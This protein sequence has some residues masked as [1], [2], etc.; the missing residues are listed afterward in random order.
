VHIPTNIAAGF[1]VL[2]IYTTN[3]AGE[4]VDIQKTVYVAASSND[5]DGDGVLNVASPCLVVAPT[6]VDSDGDGIDDGCDADVVATSS[7]VNISGMVE[8][9]TL[10]E[11]N[12]LTS[13]V[14]ASVS[15][16]NDMSRVRQPESVLGDSTR[17]S[18]AVR[19]PAQK[20][21]A[22]VRWI[23]PYRLDW[24]LVSALGL[25]ITVIATCVIHA[26]TQRRG[27]LKRG[28]LKL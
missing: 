22:T 16:N 12:T 27:K 24:K 21:D 1:H 14:T 6:G 3:M 5:Y 2:H 13:G 18:S 20:V 19:S 4:T 10:L 15:V 9:A 25:G 26:M 7:R 23:Q 11:Q 8:A 28:I 17:A